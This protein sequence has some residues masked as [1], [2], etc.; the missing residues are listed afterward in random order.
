MQAIPKRTIVTVAFAVTLLAVG[1]G[2]YILGTEH[3][4]GSP[5]DFKGTAAET[6]RLVITPQFDS[7]D[8]FSE[9]IAAVRIGDE[10]TGKYGY[11][12]KTG[13]IVINPQFDWTNHFSEGLASVRVGDDKT[14][15]YGYINKSG[16]YAI[17]PQFDYASNFSEGLAS[18]RIGDDKTGK[19]G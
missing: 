5:K 12:D 1:V 7:A 18:V 15:K 3:V 13:K 2:S 4:S 6:G 19:W 10:K 17:N 14:G 8:D 9:G 11:I 16:E